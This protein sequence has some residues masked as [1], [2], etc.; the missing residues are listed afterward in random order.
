MRC[1]D[2]GRGHSVPRIN[3]TIVFLTG[4]QEKQ[5]P[6]RLVFFLTGEQEKQEPLRLVFF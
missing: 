4:E 1:D 3:P 2:S 6:L 5:E